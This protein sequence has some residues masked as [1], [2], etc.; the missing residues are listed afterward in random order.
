MLL[1]PTLDKLNALRLFAMAEALRRF[2]DTT[3]APDVT[4][5]ELVAILADAEWLWRD[6]RRLK[7][8]LKKAAFR[9]P[10]SIEDVDYAH[11]R[12][13]SKQLFRELGSS[14]WVREKKNI[15]LTGPTGIGKSYL[16]CALGQKACRDGFVVQYRRV[17]RLFDELAQARA[18]GTLPL[19]MRRLAKADVLILDDFGPQ[20]LSASERRD[21]LEV[22]DDRCGITSTVV[23]SQLK[24]N[25]WHS[26][27]ADVTIADSI[28]DRL[29]HTAHR[30]ELEGESVRKAQAK[31]NGS[32]TDLTGDARADK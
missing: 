25:L 20:A 22:I 3:P 32:K 9:L 15:I 24:P 7:S 17:I 19:A 13:L 21:L 14:R 1:E 11:P 8:R 2:V 6:N 18:D 4:P 12:G 5:T 26:V 29:V 27:I 10:A 30:I 16:A 28:C 23:T 31:K